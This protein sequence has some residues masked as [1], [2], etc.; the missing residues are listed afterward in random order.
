V[1]PAGSGSLS[2]YSGRDDLILERFEDVDHTATDDTD[3][4]HLADEQRAEW[5]ALP[6]VAAV[7]ATRELGDGAVQ[8][9]RRTTRPACRPTRRG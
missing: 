2:R 4:G 6:S 7:D 8:R 1:T 5:A 9:F 3:G